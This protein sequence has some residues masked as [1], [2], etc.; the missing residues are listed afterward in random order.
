MSNDYDLKSVKLPRLAGGAMEAFAGLLENPATGALLMPKLLEDG[1]ITKLRSLQ[2]DEPPTFLPLYPAAAEGN[3]PLPDTSPLPTAAQSDAGFKFSTVRDYTEAYRAGHATPEDV[4]ERVLQAIADSD[5]QTPP[6]RAF[7]ASFHDDVMAQARASTQRIREGK[8]LGIFDGVPVAIKDEVDQV[9]Y[10]TTVGT[11]FLGRTPATS[12]STVVARMRAAGALLIGKANMHEIGINPVGIN[13]HHGF[14]RNP[15]APDHYPGGSSSG[16]A[17]AVAAGLCPV[18]LG[19]DGGGSIRIP[20]ALCGIVGLKATFGRVSEVGAYPLTWSMGHLGPIAATAADAALMYSVIAGPDAADSNSLHQPPV[21]VAGV[22][23]TDLRGLTLGV[24]RPW[25]N[26]ATPAIVAACEAMLTTLTGM[27]A[28][29]REIEIPELDAARVA[30]A[31]TILSEMAA[32]MAR[33]YKEHRRDFGGDVRI[34]LALGRV[35]TSRDYVQAQRVRT[36]TMAHFAR[37]LTEVDVIVSPATAVT[38]PAIPSG[39]LPQGESDLSTVTE[40]MR[41]VVPGNFVGLPAISFPAGYDE[42]GL[43]IG[44]H[45]MGRPWAEALLLRLAHAAGP[46][47]ARRKPQAFYELLR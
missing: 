2:V 1:G 15:Y 43:P 10:G 28:T 16:P 42:G 41:Y 3:A 35:F 44:F 8:A 27:G 23:Q 36:R 11:K 24:Y 19:A 14:A 46:T 6:L 17:V 18:A 12:D 21:S 47:V 38:A 13:A 39:A 33:F 9:P 26:H 22:G 29:V 5:R 45:A 20:A 32:S 30:H 31:V 25:F 4:A 7:I 40:L 37:A 34:N